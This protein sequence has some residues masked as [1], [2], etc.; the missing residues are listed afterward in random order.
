MKRAIILLLLLAGIGLSAQ[1]PS[2]PSVAM[3]DEQL[4]F[5][6]Y[7][8]VWK[9]LPD[10][11]EPDL[12]NRGYSIHLFFDIPIS[13]SSFSLAIGA[14]W[15]QHNLY[16]NAYPAR[17]NLISQ[18]R[19][20]FYLVPTMVGTNAIEYSLNRMSLGYLSMPLE[21]RYRSRSELKFKL[22]IGFTGGMLLSGFMKYK[23]SDYMA[24]PEETVKWK[25]YGIPNALPY[26]YGV[27]FRIGI[28]Q[29]GLQY[30]YQLPSVFITDKGPDVRPVSV[31]L[32]YHPI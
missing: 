25:R 16:S 11:V 13:T 24:N 9:G 22:S 20:Q 1:E 21:F 18:G 12:I 10:D 19:T 3:S 17:D 5:S 7:S 26:T 15:Q 6:F 4:V 8:D 23:G 29:W 32:T 27:S 30:H 14:G 28:R 2:Y 31:G